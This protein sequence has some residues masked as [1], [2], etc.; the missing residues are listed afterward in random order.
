MTRYIENV[1]VYISQKKIKQTF[2][3]LKSGIDTKKLSRILTGAQDISGT[4]MEKI[5]KALGQK[6]EFF[7]REDFIVP[8]TEE[9]TMNQFAFYAGEPNREQE[10]FA[11]QLIELIQNADEV[12]SA[13][14]RYLWLGGE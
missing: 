6:V 1:N 4:D 10:D 2:I 14:G 9:L 11:L 3:S 7:L 12:L 5:A 8:V 13:E